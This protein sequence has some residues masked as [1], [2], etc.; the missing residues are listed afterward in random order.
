MS[1]LS[2]EQ[3]KDR[4]RKLLT[5]ECRCGGLSLPHIHKGIL[6]ICRI[7]EDNW[8]D[9]EPQIGFKILDTRSFSFNGINYHLTA[10]SDKVSLTPMNRLLISFSVTSETK[11]INS[12]SIDKHDF[13]RLIERLAI[14]FK[15][16]I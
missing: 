16:T 5:E 11:E 13:P 15:R 8:P 6:P 7:Y 4:V 9:N 1:K 3:V 10:L 12:L 2:F 14:F